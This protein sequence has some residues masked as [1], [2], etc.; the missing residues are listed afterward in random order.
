MTDSKVNRIYFW[1]WA[2]A[3]RRGNVVENSQ[4]SKFFCLTLA[5]F[6]DFQKSKIRNY[7]QFHQS[8]TAAI[9]AD[10][11][12]LRQNFHMGYWMSWR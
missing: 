4:K 5:V 1:L 6:C 7:L 9:K 11:G 10:S 8:Q 2:S 3:Y 12:L